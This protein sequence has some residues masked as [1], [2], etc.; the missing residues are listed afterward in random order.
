MSRLDRLND[1][2][3]ASGLDAVALMPGANLFYL[4]GLS[5]HLM[6]RPTVAFFPVDRPP[7]IVVPA[8]ELIKLE[9]PG[10]PVALEPFSYTDAEGPGGAFERACA[11][12]GLAGARLGVEALRMR[13]AELRLIER[14]APGVRTELVE[15][16]MARLRM[17][18][19]EQEL[20]HMRRAVALA[21]RA[22]QLALAQVRPGMS[23]RDVSAVLTQAM[24]QSGASGSEEMPFSPIV[25][26]GPNSALPHGVPGDRRVQPG[27][28]LLLDFG[29]FSGGYASDITRT[30]AVGSI[31]PELERVYQIVKEANA[32][33]RE[34]ARPGVAVQEVDRAARRVIVEAGYGEYFTHRTGHGLGLEGHELPSVVEGNTLELAPGMTFTVEPGIYL[35]GKGGVRIEDDVVITETGAES[36]T[37]F[38]RDLI[39]IG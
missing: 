8:L 35:P 24:L 38:G 26:S 13:V 19:D 32:A 29:V 17:V 34:A 7:A 3:R 10:L 21:E 12:L 15:E 9:Q 30:F 31:D 28:L 25:L 23:E 6:E 16:M 5:F 14:Y 37:T 33:G 22:L 18:K 20:A 36:L 27:D 2:M 11:A 39:R 4:T 1:L